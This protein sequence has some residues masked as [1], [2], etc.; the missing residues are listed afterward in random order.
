VTGAP[1]PLLGKVPIDVMLREGGDAGVPLVL[2]HPE[3]VVARQLTEIATALAGR[4]RGLA[5]RPLGLS[6]V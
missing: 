5:G 2:G 3:S 1:V 6:P 4:S